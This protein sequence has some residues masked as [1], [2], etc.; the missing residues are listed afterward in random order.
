MPT[1]NVALSFILIALGMLGVI[2]SF[3]VQDRKKYLISIVLSGIII[4]AGLMQLSS[5]SFARYQWQMRM[6]RLQAQR[7]SD[8]E[9]LRKRLQDKTTPQ[10]PNQPAAATKK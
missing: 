3:L 5:Q 6:N 4:V 9:D 10:T 7:Q 1:S 2:L 8:L